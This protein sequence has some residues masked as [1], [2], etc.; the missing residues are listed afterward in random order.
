MAT[1]LALPPEVLHNVLKAVDPRDLAT[2][3]R[4]CRA[5]HTFISGNRQ[6]FKELYLQRLACPH[7]PK[8]A[9]LA[10]YDLG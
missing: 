5:L 3:P 1:L 8:I 10:N 7:T 2:L 6:L 4:T 9:I